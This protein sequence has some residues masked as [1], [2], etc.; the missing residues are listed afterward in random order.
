MSGK[1]LCEC[2]YESDQATLGPEAPAACPGCG[3]AYDVSIELHPDDGP[4]R[5][6]IPAEEPGVHRVRVGSHVRHIPIPEVPGYEIL[7]E[8][9]R[10]GMGIVYKARQRRLGRT[11]AL[12]MILAGAH[13]T[14]LERERF[15]KEA[16]A[17]AALQHPGIVQIFEI[18]EHEGQPFLTLEFVEGGSLA[19]KLAERADL[20]PAVNAAAI[21]QQLSLAV[22]YAHD[23]G[24][25]HRDLKPANVLLVG[26][27]PLDERGSTP[28][29]TPT[30]HSSFNIRS[31]GTWA[32]AKV[33][34]FGLAKR[35]DE[36]LAAQQG[37]KTGAVMGTPSYISPEQA[38]GKSSK[39]TPLTD[40]YSL[41]AILYEL[42]TGRP[43]FKADTAVETV[44]QVLNEDPVAPSRLRPKCPRDLETIC[45]KCLS[46]DPPSRY[47]SAADLG[48]DLGRFL[49]HEPILARPLSPLARGVKWGRRHPAITVFGITAF[50][51]TVSVVVVLALAYAKVQQGNVEREK[52]AKLARAEQEKAERSRIEAERLNVELKRA[53]EETHRQA[54][55]LEQK[56]DRNERDRYALQ[57]SQIA[58]LVERNPKRALELLDDPLRCPARLRDF[59][60]RYL[61][62]LCERQ[63]YMYD[64][65]AAPIL[66][67]AVNTDGTIVASADRSGQVRL[68]SPTTRLSY[69]S[70]VGH[71]GPVNAIAFSPDGH[72]IATVGDD[73]AIRLF[74]LTPSFLGIVKEAHRLL[75]QMPGPF[76]PK[77]PG[78]MVFTT[79]RPNLVIKA[80]TAHAR[81]IAFCPDGRTLAA[82]GSD[83][84]GAKPDG[85]LKVWDLAGRA[86]SVPLG[87]VLGSAAAGEHFTTARGAD[88]QPYK[89]VKTL[90]G[91][92]FQPIICL[93]FS[94]NGQ[95]LASGSEDRSIALTPVLGEAK[96][97][98]L[99]LQAS[100]V[101][102]LAFS[103]DGKTLATVDNAADSAVKLWDLTGRI[104]KVRAR[105][106]GHANAIYALA[107]SPDGQLIASAGFDRSVRLWDAATGEERGRFAGHDQ[108]VRGLAFLPDKHSLL[109][110]GNDNK[111]RI[112]STA[113]SSAETTALEAERPAIISTAAF[114]GNGRFMVTGDRNGQ[115]RVWMHNSR[116]P[117]NALP[118]T[119]MNTWTPVAAFGMA[120]GRKAEVR[121]VAI[122]E[123]G[124]YV[125]AAGDEGMLVWDLTE[126]APGAFGSGARVLLP[127]VLV[128][129]KAVYATALAPDGKTLA[130]ADEEGVWLWDI[131]TG[132][133]MRDT[134]LMEGKGVRDLEFAPQKE[135]A[136]AVRLLA[137]AAGRGFKIF[138]LDSGAKFTQDIAHASLVS[139]I[140]FAP[141][142][143]ILATGSDAGGVHTWELERTGK[144]IKLTN[145]AES[146]GHADTITDLR[147]TRDGQTLI[148]ASQD[149]AVML[150]DPHTVQERL[151]LTGHTDRIVRLGVSLQDKALLSVGRDGTVK[152]W[153]AE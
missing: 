23:Q 123:T 11:V 73:G 22:Q 90:K 119:V 136:P 40:V 49:R 48:A 37:T 43:P 100:A 118:T 56:Q 47:A 27:A 117:A 95:T 61:R 42:L 81:S 153:R 67:A 128:G 86:L 137:V 70:L 39:I 106:T 121:S 15:R 116:A 19:Q 101:F 36:T 52:E 1:F 6:I 114:S 71:V 53:L 62:R 33:T 103:P 87:G 108:Q 34:D 20:M 14:D 122:S 99:P 127:K 126:T 107:Y 97:E 77:F 115:T 58:T 84:G 54:D 130:A 55:E 139:S 96:S 2:G 145:R 113:V 146:A 124:R 76:T 31:S 63:T 4:T 143:R 41:G 135:N 83:R 80:F 35:I 150:W 144:E 104:P 12:K 26:P 112:W 9:G 45:L 51:A 59:T 66:S 29:P 82:G 78:S 111:A 69:G 60:W 129:K 131:T 17:V 18:G 16:E 151:T 109:S 50:L 38:S 92:H 94:P 132:K 25:I 13:A 134:P 46:K 110:V 88:N 91:L 147:F 93:A 7:G 141:G 72:T 28:T 140:A 32:L 133:K 24:V 142:G 44:L 64:G 105:M 148:S 149:R 68:W 79:F 152:R 57:L 74:D 10:G 102:S 5:A 85:L 75:P 8:L 98:L 3:R 65:H 21:V 125:V 89:L 120:V 30:P 138:D